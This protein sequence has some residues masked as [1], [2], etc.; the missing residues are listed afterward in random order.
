MCVP[1][2]HPHVGAEGVGLADVQPVDRR[3]R[4]LAGYRPAE[5]HEH[6]L[7]AHLHMGRGLRDGWGGRR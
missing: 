4:V 5:G 2:R 1:G 6:R 7:A 3:Q